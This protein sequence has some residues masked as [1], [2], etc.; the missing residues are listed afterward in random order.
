MTALFVLAAGL[1]VGAIVFQSAVV[2]P[3]VFPN[4]SAEDAKRLLRTIFPRFYVLGLACGAVMLATAGVA[5]L[6]E[7]AGGKLP[8][9]LAITAVMVAL[10]AV[11]LWLVP[12]INRARDA[13]AERRFQRLHGV[14]VA[15]TLAV[16]ALGCTAIVA[17]AG[18]PL[19]GVA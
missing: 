1:W 15:L 18:S 2:A 7:G 19:G 13:H 11:S 12:R 14:S 10:N 4:V 6:R 16:L 8:A 3:S 9:L 17:A 5:A